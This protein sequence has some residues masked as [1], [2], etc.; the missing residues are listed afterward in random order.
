MDLNWGGLAT[1]KIWKSWLVIYFL[2]TR[3]EPQKGFMCPLWCL[4]QSDV[5][6][7]DVLL[8]VKLRVKINACIPGVVN[9]MSFILKISEKL[10]INNTSVLQCVLSFGYH[11]WRTTPLVSIR[12]QLDKVAIGF[13]IAFDFVW[14]FH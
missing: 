11:F 14:R 10:K 2:L 12:W 13:F 3:S 8:N 9:F 6:A 4:L 7:V 1:K 5:R